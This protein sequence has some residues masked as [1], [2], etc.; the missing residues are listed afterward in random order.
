MSAAIVDLNQLEDVAKGDVA[1]VAM[2][3]SEVLAMTSCLRQARAALVDMERATRDLFGSPASLCPVCGCWGS[4]LRPC[5]FGDA[6]KAIDI[7]LRE[8]DARCKVEASDA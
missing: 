5:A 7:A 2:R 3:P 6:L 1:T 8:I 4:H